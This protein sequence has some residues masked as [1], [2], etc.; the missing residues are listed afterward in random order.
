MVED[1]NAH[2]FAHGRQAQHAHFSGL[3]AGVERVV[4]VQLARGDMPEHARARFAL[5]AMRGGDV[6]AGDEAGGAGD[7]GGSQEAAAGEAGLFRGLVGHG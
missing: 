6:R 1:G 5:L 3:A 2:E 4:F 7:G